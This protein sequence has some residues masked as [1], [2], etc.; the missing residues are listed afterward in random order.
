MGRTNEASLAAEREE[1]AQRETAQLGKPLGSMPE[2]EKDRLR[3]RAL[4]VKEARERTKRAKT[5][6]DKGVAPPTVEESEDIIEE[7]EAPLKKAKM[8]K[9]KEV[10]VERDTSKKPTESELFAHLKNGVAWPATRFN[11]VKMME[12]LQMEDDIKLMLEHMNMQSFY[13][14]AYPTY[15]EVSCQFLSSLEATFHS[16][17]H[18]K[19]GWGR[20]KFKVN[21]RFYSMGFKDIGEV[22]GLKDLKESSI[23]T[24]AATSK[25]EKLTNL[26]WKLLAG[27][28]RKASR[29]KNASIRHPTVRYLHRLIV[30]T[31]FPRKEPSNVPDEDLEFLHQTV[32][33]FASPP[34]LPPVST[35]FYK[36]F[37]MVGFFVKRHMYY[38]DWAW[39]TPDS[40]PQ[41]GI[42][43]LIT[44]LLEHKGIDLGKDA[45]GP[46]FLDGNYLKKAQYFSGRFHGICV[47]SY[48]QSTKTVEVL[49]PNWELTSLTEP[50]AISFDIGE[51][52]FLGSH[53]PLGLMSSPKKKK[54]ADKCNVFQ[55]DHTSKNKE[56]LFGPPRYH[57]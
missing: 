24:L 57:F 21:G 33:H 34:Q 10:A 46:S 14:M 41:I 42:G 48:L 12:E 28:D 37:G 6:R 15:K 30:H 3:Q 45:T 5:Q 18:V 52:H 25:E 50:G 8:S 38:K 26:V 35:D 20:I 32:Q 4:D 47:Y 51:E 31:I 23:P 29:D 1:A 56:F 7:E 9:G 17:K 2:S 54:S 53:G 55:P 19:Q 44:P 36:N 16:S 11:D 43:G 49:L 40:D 27:K 13:S 39:T 22:L